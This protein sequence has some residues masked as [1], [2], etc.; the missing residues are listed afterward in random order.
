MNEW[1]ENHF[2]PEARRHLTGNSF[3]ADA[4]ILLILDNCTDHLSLEILVKDKVSV[5]FFPPNY[6]SL[7]QLMDMGI[8]RALKC[9]YKSEFLTEMLS[10][11]NGGATLQNFLKSYNL[12]MAVWSAAKAWDG[13]PTTPMKN[14]WHNLWPA[15]IFYEDEENVDTDFKSQ[16]K[17]LKFFNYLSTS[18]QEDK[19][20]KIMPLKYCIA[21]IKPRQCVSSPMPKYA[22]WC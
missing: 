9:R 21:T 7:I 12:K 8:L 18:S 20:L 22:V 10:F 17:K 11:L 1:F 14:A 4:K 2:V 5:L 19:K 16:K 6:T 13:I 3:P 15:T